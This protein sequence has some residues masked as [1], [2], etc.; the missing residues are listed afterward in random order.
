MF[1]TLNYTIQ[2]KY[3]IFGKKKQMIFYQGKVLQ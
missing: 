3:L 1:L 2:K